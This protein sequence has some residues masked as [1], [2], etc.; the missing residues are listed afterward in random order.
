MGMGYLYKCSTSLMGCL[1]V[2]EGQESGKVVGAKHLRDT[3]PIPWY[4]SDVLMFLEWSSDF[5]IKPRHQV[6][7]AVDGK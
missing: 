6:A 5:K 1:H 4:H 7:P 2:V 3:D